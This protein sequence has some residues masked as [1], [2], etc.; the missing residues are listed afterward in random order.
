VSAHPKGAAF[1]NGDFQILGSEQMKEL[2]YFAYGSN[3]STKRLKAR[4]PSAKVLGTGI[5]DGYA[6]AFHKVSQNDGSA[7]CDIV[8]SLSGQVLGVLFEISKPDKSDLDRWEGL[9]LGYEEMMVEIRTETGNTVSA[10]TYF[11]TITDREL[12]PFTWYKRHVLEG[13]R[14]AGLLS[15]YIKTIESIPATEDDDKQREAKELAIYS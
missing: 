3:M 1:I 10:F 2:I 7:K 9:N 11:A 5:L 15:A 14:E 13:A 8:E 6:L 12:Q 4:A